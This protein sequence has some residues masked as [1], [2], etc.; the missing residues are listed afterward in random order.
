MH[1]VRF[2]RL[3]FLRLFNTDLCW[4]QHAEARLDPRVFVDPTLRSRRDVQF[5]LPRAVVPVE[6]FTRERSN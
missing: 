1:H 6:A 2:P 3:G 4:R 5:V